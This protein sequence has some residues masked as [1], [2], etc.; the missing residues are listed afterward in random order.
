MKC[1]LPCLVLVLAAVPL[2]AAPA[3][4]R[5]MTYYMESVGGSEGKC[6][7]KWTLPISG[8]YQYEL[9]S[10]GRA[11]M[12]NCSTTVVVGRSSR[13]E[14]KIC[15]RVEEWALDSDVMN[16]T[17]KGQK[18]GD[19]KVM[20]F[21]D[22]KM[23]KVCFEGISL[24]IHVLEDRNYSMIW[25]KGNVPKNPYSFKF[26]LYPKCPG[27]P[28]NL[29]EDSDKDSMD[30]NKAKELEAMTT[31][32]IVYGV[33]V[34]LIICSIFLVVLLLTY[35]YYKNNPQGRKRRS[36]QK[37]SKLEETFNKEKKVMGEQVAKD[38]RVEGHY[39]KTDNSELQPLVSA[40]AA[41]AAAAVVTQD[42][43]GS[44]TIKIS[45]EP[46]DDKEEPGEE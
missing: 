3:V 5:N 2:Y 10:N 26:V 9:V 27:Y 21:G 39:K 19:M 18:D 46:A 28:K 29:M 24:D 45:E 41:P 22:E 42:D 1:Y 33:I 30:F 34:A 4:M 38:K 20:K 8:K 12:G 44:P 6:G 40:A 25:A 36:Q 13:C 31:M 43:H 23:T 35:C 37:S 14:K 11:V 15:V 16:V 17:F 7:R 32:N